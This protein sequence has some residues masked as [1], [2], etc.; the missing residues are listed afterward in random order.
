MSFVTDNGLYCYWV[1]HFGLKNA[2][3]T[4]Q[5]LV[6][7]MFARQIGR[8]MEVY[9]DDM[10]VKSVKAS[11]HIADLGKTFSILR[12]Y[13]IKLNPTKCAFGVGSSKFLSFQVSQRDIEANPDKIRAL[14]DMSSPQT[15]EE[16]QCFTGR[17]AALGR[18]ISRAIDKCLPFFQQLKGHKK[19]GYG[20]SQ[21]QISKYG[22]TGLQSGHL[23][24]EVA[25][26]LPST[27]HYRPHRF[28]FPIGA[29]EARTKFTASSRGIGDTNPEASSNLEAALVIPPA[30]PLLK[31]IEAEAAR[32]RGIV[33]VAPDATIILYAIRLSFKASNNVVEYEAL[34]A[35]L[36]LAANLGVRLLNVRCDSQLVVN[37]VSVEYEAKEARIIAYL[38]KVRKLS[39][40]F[41]DCV[42]SQIPRVKNSLVD[43]LAKLAST[44]EGQISRIVL[45]EILDNP[46][47]NRAD[48][49]MVNPVQVPTT[50]MDPIVRYLTTGEVPEDGLEAQRLKVRATRYVILNDTL[51][52][53]GYSQPYLRCLRL[54]EAKYVIREVHEG[55]CENHSGG[56]ALAQKVLHQAY[57]WPTIREDFKSFVQRCDKCQRFDAIPR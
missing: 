1:M 6:N 3:A 22:E 42:I 36:R 57:L 25:L 46:S 2:G 7:Q 20:S 9:V 31:S 30:P 33:L 14:L 11:D 55:I 54:D 48:Q 16:I 17:V 38:V 56:C 49:E 24:S 23:Y 26:I 18:F 10:L 51:Y 40:K 47:I 44:T 19:Q 39:E 43:A 12:E 5:R 4:Y 37:Q 8:T 35:I 50:W 52:K 53:K 34:L 29:A 41:R 28:T 21:Y 45:V 13:Q 15:M 32:R 27:F